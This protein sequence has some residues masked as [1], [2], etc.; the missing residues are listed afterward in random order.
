MAEIA[1]KTPVTLTLK[2]GVSMVTTVT[3]PSAGLQVT[4][5]E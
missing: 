1:E 4:G 5:N 3:G 2:G